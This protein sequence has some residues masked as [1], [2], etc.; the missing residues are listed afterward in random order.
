M[1][2]LTGSILIGGSDNIKF[3]PDAGVPWFTG[4]TDGKAV[5]GLWP[6]QPPRGLAHTNPTHSG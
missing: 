1:S 3:I 5:S 6:T 4:T 2:L